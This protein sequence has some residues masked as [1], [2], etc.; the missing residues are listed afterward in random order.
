ME[1]PVWPYQAARAAR[2]TDAF[3]ADVIRAARFAYRH[4]R[5]YLASQTIRPYCG[6][7]GSDSRSCATSLVHY[8]LMAERP[9][10]ARAAAQDAIEYLGYPSISVAIAARVGATISIVD[11]EKK[12]LYTP[13]AKC[14]SSTVKN[15]FVF[16]M[17]GHSSRRAHRRIGEAYRLVY[18]NELDTK[19]ADYY[20]FAIVRDPVD[21]YVSYF[22]K[23]IADGSLRRESRHL[24]MTNGLTTA[25][26]LSETVEQ[27]HR[28]RQIFLDFRVHTDPMTLWAGSNPQSYSRM[29]TMGELG[30]IRS[31]LNNAYETEIPDKRL[32]V[33]KKGPGGN[34]PE[35]TAGERAILT[36]FYA[37]DY[38][39]LDAI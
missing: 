25:P 21:R 36:E 37:S 1:A 34:K 4:G 24:D 18:F 9:N 19:Y 31:Y 3:P 8:L 22:N 14:G 23:N 35:L 26:S 28:Y 6:G 30:E 38:A 15:Y 16:A 13:F 29:Y 33:S 12:I 20:K 2:N 32:T 11:E 7:I 10:D 5:P 27:I 39:F 17:F